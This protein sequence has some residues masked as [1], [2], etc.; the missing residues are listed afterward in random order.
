M[1]SLIEYITFLDELSTDE[2]IRRIKDRDLEIKSSNDKDFISD[3]TDSIIAY[4][5]IL[6][7]RNVDL[8]LLDEE[9]FNIVKKYNFVVRL[10]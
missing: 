5:R 8:S 7:K 9:A 10:K 6:Q 1:V 4:N 3:K 2:L